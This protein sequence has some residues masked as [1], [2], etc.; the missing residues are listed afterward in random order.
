MVLPHAPIYTSV[1]DPAGVPGEFASWPIRT[2]F[3][4][5]IPLPSKY[6][7]A[8]LPLMPMAF[9]RLRLDDFDLVLTVSSA[10]SKNVSVR[11]NARNVC[12]CLTP[13]RYLWD[14]HDAYIGT[15]AA[16]AAAAPIA[17]WLRRADLKAAGRVDRFV[18]ISQTV[19]QRVE[20]TY[21]RDSEVIF[22]PV[23]TR[24]FAGALPPSNAI[25]GYFLVVSRLIRYKRIDLAVDACTRMGRRLLIVGTGPMREALGKR[26]GPTVEFLGARS[27]D[28]V[29]ALL[30][31]CDAFL[32][33]GHEDFGIAPVEAQAA[34][35][36]VIGFGAGGLAETVVD[37]ATGV[38]FGEQ[39]VESLIDGIERFDRQVW[40]AWACRKN[41]E[42]FDSSAFRTHIGA[43]IDSEIARA[44]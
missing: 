8:M 36:P 29:T 10:F 12:Y 34:G 35:R 28:E 40:D 41:A 3:L 24:R 1:F 19:A 39:S 2:T 23:D 4:Q 32:F 11:A 30:R 27:D 26:A 20:A 43:L 14:L 18:A 33:P 15:A 5:R 16:R 7:R 13:P 42:R 9:S 21:H 6:S 17:A 44:R 22:P 25:P 38:L 37:G 31:G